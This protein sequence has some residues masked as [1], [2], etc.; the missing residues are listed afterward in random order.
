MEEI[1]HGIR[2]LDFSRYRAGPTCGQILADMGADVIR[3]ER[4]GG[5]D[6]RQLICLPLFVEC[7]SPL[8]PRESSPRELT[9]WIDSPTL[10]L[11]NMS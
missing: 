3:V 2:V 8:A 1:L 10:F 9:Y 5:E 4:P 11:A 7:L 6:D